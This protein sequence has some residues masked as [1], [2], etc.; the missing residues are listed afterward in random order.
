LKVSPPSF[1]V[2]SG[3]FVSLDEARRKKFAGFSVKTR[4]EDFFRK[5]FLRDRV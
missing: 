1:G 3:S 2:K 5:P 4:L